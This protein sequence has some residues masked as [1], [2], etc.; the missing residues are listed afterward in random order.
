MADR[1]EALRA[2]VGELLDTSPE[3]VTDDFSLRHK[4]LMG[5]IGGTLLATAVKS[6]LGAAP[7]DLSGASTFGELV[8][9]VKGSPGNAPGTTPGVAPGSGAASGNGSSVSSNGSANGVA[10]GVASGGA[11]SGAI[12]GLVCGVDIEQVDRLP[13]CVDYWG[14]A[15]Y[16]GNFTPGEIAYCAGQASPR[17]H[18]A[19]RWCAKEALRKCGARYAP[20][21]MDRVQVA[22]RPDGGVFLQV[23]GDGEAWLNVGASLSLSHT[24]QT[25][26]AM[27]VMSGGG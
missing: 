5:S 10:G 7:G 15:F 1:R 24:D 26:V 2:L 23:S 13:E 6:K 25:A 16:T 12:P 21:A 19:A 22:R 4:R 27:V 9:L 17:E 14:E 20:L 18:F 3:R 8:A 11:V